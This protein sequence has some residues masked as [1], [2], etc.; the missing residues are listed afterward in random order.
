MA[1]PYRFVPDG[2]ELIF[3]KE[4][5]FIG[6]GRNFYALNLRTGQERQLTNLK[7]NLQMRT[8]DVTLDGKQIVFDRLRQNSDIAMIDLPR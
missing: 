6:G 3:V 2:S 4:G 7:T 8:F 5:A 1:T